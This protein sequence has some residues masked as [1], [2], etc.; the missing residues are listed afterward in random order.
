MSMYREEITERSTSRVQEHEMIRT[1]QFF[2]VKIW[3]KGLGRQS[4]KNHVG[5]VGL[6]E[7]QLIFFWPNDARTVFL[8][9]VLHCNGVDRRHES[10]FQ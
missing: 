1:N 2:R 4:R 3:K 5:S 10:S 9:V 7:T 8:K 6:P